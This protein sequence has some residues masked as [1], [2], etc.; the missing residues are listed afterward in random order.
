MKPVCA[1]LVA[2][3]SI[4]PLA[5][6]ARA[7]AAV[8]VL[9]GATSTSWD[10]DTPDRGSYSSLAGFAAGGRLD[11]DIYRSTRLSLQPSFMQKGTRIDFEVP[12]EN[13][14]VDSVEVR[15]DY[16]A[17]PIL[18]R[19]ETLQGRFY[20]TGGFEV[21]W[22]L[23]ARYKTPD[24]DLD[25]KIDMKEHSLAVDFGIG[26]TIP[27]GRTGIW[28]ELRYSQS[29]VN[30]GNEDASSTVHIIREPRVKNS[31]ILFLAGIL[32]DL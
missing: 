4:F 20:V 31:G 28:F 29:L 10:G 32:Y 23:D 1:F 11:I 7:G 9:A 14:R 3:L 17:L 15:L 19:V 8:G 16:F 30:V 25:A 27:A 13:E 6:G 12:G 22:L 18:V 26:Y 21:G 24:E 2:A 5:G